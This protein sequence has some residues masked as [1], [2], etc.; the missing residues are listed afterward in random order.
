MA[1]DYTNYTSTYVSTT[2]T[3]VNASTSST[4]DSSTSHTETI[5]AVNSS[6]FYASATPA[7]L[8][9]AL[10][11]GIV[12][13]SDSSTDYQ[14][15]LYLY[16][17]SSSSSCSNNNLVALYG[18]VDTTYGFAVSVNL[19]NFGYDCDNRQL[20]FTGFM[21]V[22]GV[23][24]TTNYTVDIST[25]LP[26]VSSTNPCG[27]T[28]NTYDLTDTPYTTTYSF[29]AGTSTS[30]FLTITINN[31][32]D[33]NDKTLTPTSISLTFT[34]APST[35]DDYFNVFS[36]IG[37]LCMMFYG[38]GYQASVDEDSTSETQTQT[39]TNQTQTI[40]NSIKIIEMLSA[41]SWWYFVPDYYNNND[42]A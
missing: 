17:N 6:T 23:N 31:Q 16:T 27:I 25:T 1:T 10:T 21:D 12:S 37:Y 9:C 18:N 33:V 30:F 2:K 15:W 35:N 22:Y 42:W 14:I 36:A 3:T 4:F 24:T 11:Q 28:L 5:T 7:V 34:S 19:S 41:L 13:M 32:Y 38:I 39:I 29:Y 40:N 20:F 8:G 26:V